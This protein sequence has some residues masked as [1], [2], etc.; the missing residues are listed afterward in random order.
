MAKKKGFKHSMNRAFNPLAPDNEILGSKLLGMANAGSN[1]LLSLIMGAG[2][3]KDGGRV[4][5]VGKA[6]HGY[7]KAMKK[8]GKK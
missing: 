5:G 7:G 2:L 3:F 8:Q 4:R 6:T 1:S